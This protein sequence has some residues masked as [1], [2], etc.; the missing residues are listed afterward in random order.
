MI[1]AGPGFDRG[2]KLD[3]LVSLIDVTPILCSIA[4]AYK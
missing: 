2:T 3:V 4:A 1:F